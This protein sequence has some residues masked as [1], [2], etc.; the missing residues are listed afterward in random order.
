MLSTIFLSDAKNWCD[1]KVPMMIVYSFDGLQTELRRTLPT[2]ICTVRL[3]ANTRCEMITF[4]YFGICLQGMLS[5]SRPCFGYC[6]QK[7]MLSMYALTDSHPLVQTVVF[8]SDADFIHII[9]FIYFGTYLPSISVSILLLLR[10][11]AYCHTGNKR[12][13]IDWL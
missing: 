8:C 13:L 12:R 4:L 3:P 10:W 6:T 11:C 2:W 9:W 7:F 5:W 1:W